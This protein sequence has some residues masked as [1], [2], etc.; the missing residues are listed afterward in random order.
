LLGLLTQKEIRYILVAH[1][2]ERSHQTA[3]H[4][5]DGLASH[6]AEQWMHWLPALSG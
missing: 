1:H 4:E 3:P 6:P 5:W 2:A